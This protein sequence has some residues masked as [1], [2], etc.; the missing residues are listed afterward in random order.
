MPGAGVNGS[1]RSGDEDEGSPRVPHQENFVASADGATS[2]ERGGGALARMW[3]TATDNCNVVA[4]CFAVGCPILV[5]ATG[6]RGVLEPGVA[7]LPA[8][9]MLHWRF[10]RKFYE[11]LFLLPF[12]VAAMVAINRTWGSDG[13]GVE[14]VPSMGGDWVGAW[15]DAHSPAGFLDEGR[16]GVSRRWSD[17]PALD[18]VYSLVP[19]LPILVHYLSVWLA[20]KFYKRNR[21]QIEISCDNFSNFL[22]RKCYVQLSLPTW[23]YVKKSRVLPSIATV[24]KI[25]ISISMIIATGVALG[26]PEDVIGR[27]FRPSPADEYTRRFA[28][29]H[30][31][32]LCFDETVFHC[33]IV[34]SGNFNKLKLGI[35]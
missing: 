32:M 15:D 18:V 23:L 10:Q 24:L 3:K 9:Y 35:R 22:L 5:N 26:A 1:P 14:D 2:A 13:R 28:W 4:S 6:G 33:C 29:V 27:W 12:V 30:F 19:S 21:R 20:T 16:L 31:F 17:S 11:N 8:M 7:L 25:L 34:L